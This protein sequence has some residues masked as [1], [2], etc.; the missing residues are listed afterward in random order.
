VPIG[1]EVVFPAGAAGL[2]I[3]NALTERIFRI[4]LVD[5]LGK[6]DAAIPVIADRRIEIQPDGLDCEVRIAALEF[7]IS[8]GP[9]AALPTMPPPTATPG[10]RNP[11]GS[12]FRPV[13]GLMSGTWES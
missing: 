1:I 2:G 7:G 13:S 9:G 5:G 11:V 8:L 6:L 3:E 12:F 4:T 10:D